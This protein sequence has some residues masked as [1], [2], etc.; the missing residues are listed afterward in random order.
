MKNPRDKARATTPRGSAAR[1]QATAIISCDRRG[2]EGTS[3]A[4]TARWIMQHEF[5]S[6]ATRDICGTSRYEW[7]A[8]CHRRVQALEKEG[9]K[10]R[11]H[12][13]ADQWGRS[14]GRKARAIRLIFLFLLSL[15][16]SLSLSLCTPSVCVR[17]WERGMR[18]I[19]REIYNAWTGA[20]HAVHG[21]TRGR[22]RET[23][24]SNRW[25]V[26]ARLCD[27]SASLQSN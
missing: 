3:F 20:T 16:L 5:T 7:A 22:K 18:D 11:E 17:P 26:C 2:E 24:R 19:W 13:P 10:G 14:R 27:E 9:E 23:N 4:R 21:S 15:S 8:L 12:V 25:C 6:R 1:S